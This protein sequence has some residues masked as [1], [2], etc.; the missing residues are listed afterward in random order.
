MP[1]RKVLL[2][3]HLTPVSNATGTKIVGFYCPVKGRGMLASN[4]ERRPSLLKAAVS[5]LQRGGGGLRTL[6]ERTRTDLHHE[7]I[8]IRPDER[9][10]PVRYRCD[11]NEYAESSAA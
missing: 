4:L 3:P 7:G 8:L 11:L 2:N 9:S 5:T 6:S 1:T 10:A